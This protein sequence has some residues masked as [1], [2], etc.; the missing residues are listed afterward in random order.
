M[1]GCAHGVA[2]VQGSLFYPTRNFA[3]AVTL[4]TA[5]VAL[6]PGWRVDVS[7]NLPTSP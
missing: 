6:F 4:L 1:S 3:F 2:P 5:Q 7:I